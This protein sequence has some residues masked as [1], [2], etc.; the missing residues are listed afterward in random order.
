MFSVAS[1]SRRVGTAATEADVTYLREALEVLA[2]S[3]ELIPISYWTFFETAAAHEQLTG[4]VPPSRSWFVAPSAEVPYDAGYRLRD[5]VTVIPVRA[6]E[7]LV[8]AAPSD[9]WVLATARTR[10]PSSPTLVARANTLVR[11]RAGYDL[12]AIDIAANATETREEWEKY[13]RRGCELSPN[14]CL[15]LARR[16]SETDEQAAAAEFERALANPA[17]DRVL[18]ANNSEWLVFYYERNN[19]PGR[20]RAL[21]ES[22]AKAHSHTGIRTLARL[23]ERRGEVEAAAQLFETVAKRYPT[24][25]TST[26]LGFLYRRAIVQ[27]DARF[28]R[29]WEEVKSGTFPNGLV[30]EATSADRPAAGVHVTA[31]SPASRRVRLQAGD[32]IIGV[33]GW[34]V[35]NLDQFNAVWA[36]GDQLKTHRI[37]AWRGALFTVSVPAS[38]GM[39]LDTHPLRGWIR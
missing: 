39:E 8:E 31:D 11:E 7:A 16:L 32:I 23:L 26:L 28:A 33:D 2:S 5:R 17:L 24:S 10:R 19:E 36:F 18:A 3:P 1:T 21:A 20:A 15:N 27:R 30:P 34:R 35:D 14:R 12:W 9:V 29:R 37:T 38:H 22:A 13:L 6:H 4:R 25:A